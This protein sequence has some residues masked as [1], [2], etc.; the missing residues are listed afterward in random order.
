V[1]YASQTA[2]LLT[3]IRNQRFER[4]KINHLKSFMKGLDILRIDPG[5]EPSFE[6]SIDI[7]FEK[8]IYGEPD[9]HRIMEVLEIDSKIWF[10]LGISINYD[11]NKDTIFLI[12]IEKGRYSED[13]RKEVPVTAFEVDF[14]FHQLMNYVKRLHILCCFKNLPDNFFITKKV[15]KTYADEREELIKNAE[16]QI[17]GYKLERKIYDAKD[18]GP[19][20]NTSMVRR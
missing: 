17:E 3:Q 9:L 11:I 7:N 16:Q 19:D 12:C 4:K 8:S 1:Q 2:V 18:D 5:Y 13:E 20:G 14:K 6:G 15:H 10:P